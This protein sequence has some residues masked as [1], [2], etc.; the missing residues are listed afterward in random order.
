MLELLGDSLAAQGQFLGLTGLVRDLGAGDSEF[1]DPF[2]AVV[3]TLPAQMLVLGLERV[4]AARIVTDI[5]E[6]DS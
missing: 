1:P 6:G 4:R 5:R 3:P 2:S